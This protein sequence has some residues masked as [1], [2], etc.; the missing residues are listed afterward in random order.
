MIT[1]LMHDGVATYL[2]DGVEITEAEYATL[3]R[4]EQIAA[5]STDEPRPVVRK[6]YHVALS[7]KLTE[8]QA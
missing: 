7:G 3:K 4:A 2:Q 8:V 6:R 5:T 1:I